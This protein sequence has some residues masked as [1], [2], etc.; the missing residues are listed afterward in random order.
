MN[1]FKGLVWIESAFSEYFN[2]NK[3]ACNLFF[4]NWPAKKSK[5]AATERHSESKKDT[6]DFPTEDGLDKKNFDLFFFCSMAK[7]RRTKCYLTVSNI[8]NK[9]TRTSVIFVK[10]FPFELIHLTRPLV[11]FS[12][13]LLAVIKKS[14]AS[15]F[16]FREN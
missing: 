14:F 5:L 9:M 7:P 11:I 4:R 15:S 2:Q 1:Y 8:E 13:S 6:R 16:K 12:F 3:K 10:V